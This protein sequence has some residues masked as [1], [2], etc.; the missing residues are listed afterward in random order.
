MRVEEHIVGRRQVVQ[1]LQG[2]HLGDPWTDRM[3]VEQLVR[4]AEGLEHTEEGVEQRTLAP[5][6]LRKQAVPGQLRTLVVPAE[7][8]WAVHRQEQP[9]TRLV[10]AGPRILPVCSTTKQTLQPK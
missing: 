5:G 7:R 9:H 1:A 6:L 10:A 8:T 4:I 3:W 2:P